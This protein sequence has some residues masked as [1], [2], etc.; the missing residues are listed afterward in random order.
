MYF[1]DTIRPPSF[2]DSNV[3]VTAFVHPVLEA[4][5]KADNERE[6]S[7]PVNFD[8]PSTWKFGDYLC[9]QVCTK[10]AATPCGVPSHSDALEGSISLEMF[11]PRL[12]SSRQLWR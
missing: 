6:R 12:L 7:A 10:A 9:V 2:G 1:I 5:K 4:A 3:Q 8:L 11:Q